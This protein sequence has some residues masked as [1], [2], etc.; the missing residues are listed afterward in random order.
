M[1]IKGGSKCTS[2]HHCRAAPSLK[3]PVWLACH[4][5]L[6][7][8]WNEHVA[9]IA[10]PAPLFDI[11][12]QGCIADCWR[13][14][15]LGYQLG[16]QLAQQPQ[17]TDHSHSATKGVA[18]KVDPGLVNLLMLSFAASTSMIWHAQSKGNPRNAGAPKTPQGPGDRSDCG[19]VIQKKHKHTNTVRCMRM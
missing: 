10:L 17:R 13:L 19:L 6:G 8:T 16:V 2:Q 18:C 14:C 11:H 5:T 12:R 7:S 1:R 9:E 4:W 15:R 3:G